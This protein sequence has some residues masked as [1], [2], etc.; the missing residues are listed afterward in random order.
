MTDAEI[1]HLALRL[2]ILYGLVAEGQVHKTLFRVCLQRKH[3]GDVRLIRC[4]DYPVG[5]YSSQ[6][7]DIACF[8]FNYPV[9]FIVLFFKVFA[10]NSC[11]CVP[12]GKM[13][14]PPPYPHA[15]LSEYLRAEMLFTKFDVL[16]LHRQLSG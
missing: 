13:V 1:C 11:I 15:R 12:T 3:S 9:V 6:T 4:G 10:V 2:L 7:N 8:H 14:P 5:S 16:I